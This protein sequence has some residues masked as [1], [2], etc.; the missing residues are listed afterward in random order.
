M[1]SRSEVMGTV[2]GSQVQETPFVNPKFTTCYAQ[3]QTALASAVVAGSTATVQQVSLPVPSGVRSFGYLTTFAAPSGATLIKGEA[4]IFGGRTVNRLVPTTN[5]PA[6]P[7]SAFAAAY[8]SMTA[9][10]AQAVNK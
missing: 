6:V 3:Y 7:Q 8:D 2:A 9:R 1:A 10:V 4:F 5:G